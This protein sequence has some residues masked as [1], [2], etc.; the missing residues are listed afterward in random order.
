MTVKGK[1]PVPVF[2]QLMDE[3]SGAS[4]FT[5]L[6][7]RAGF[8]QIRLK[9]GE[10]YKT[11]FQ[12]NAG[13]YEFW[14]MAF[15]LTGAPSTF[16]GAMNCTLSPCLHKFAIV[17]FDDILICSKTYE[18]HIEHI[19]LVFQLLAKDQWKVKLSKCKFAQREI[20][21]LG[22]SEHGVA[23]DNSKV[24]AILT[25]S[26]PKNV[27]ELRSFPGLAGYYRK[28]VRHSGII[29]RP[30]TN[31]L[32]KNAVFLWTSDHSQSFQTLKAALS[33]A[34]VLALSDFN[35]FCIET[36][37]CDNGVGAVLMQEGH[38]LAFIS[39]P[40]CS[41]TKGLSTYNKE[42]LAILIAVEKWRPYLQHGEFLIRT[43]QRSLAH[44]NEQRFHTPWQQKVF[45]KFLGFQYRIIYKKGSDNR[46]AN[47]LSR[48]GPDS[49]QVLA[50]A[51]YKPQWLE[52][53]S[54][55]YQNQNES[56]V[57]DILAKLAIS[58]SAVPL[59]SLK[60]GLLRYKNRIWL[61]SNKSLQH[62][63]MTA[64]HS[65]ALGGHSGVPVTYR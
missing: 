6:D 45:T 41:R 16:Q 15:G 27:K 58:P 35:K 42:Y 14:V 40:L 44:L 52:E 12:T 34:L 21:Y 23:T 26:Q 63:V 2:E 3:L 49:V 30:L 19:R 38:P 46:V 57:Q 33:F 29:S 9:S 7:L 5:N 64:L 62:R 10:E 39:K 13:H 55:G 18:E 31:L 36:D 4:W 22:I 65:T 28:F 59:F 43:D 50:V 20:K 32:K 11:A 25:W 61:G 24:Q 53:V 47:A 8:H 60:D 17:F 48:R 54:A 37:A 51:M 56:S 1:F